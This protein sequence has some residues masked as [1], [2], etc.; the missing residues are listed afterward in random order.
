MRTYNDYYDSR[1]SEIR[2]R[3]V[4]GRLV[5]EGALRIYWGVHG[6]I[7][8]KEDD[9]QRTV[10]T[11][12]KRNSC[13]Y[14]NSDLELPD[15]YDKENF[16]GPEIGMENSPSIESDISITDTMSFEATSIAEDS[17]SI[18]SMCS[19]KEVSPA[20]KSVTL[21]SKLN[22]KELDWDEIDEL[23]QVERKIDDTEK[24]YQTMPSPM[25]SQTS[26]DFSDISPTSESSKT[27]NSVDTVS[28]STNTTTAPAHQTQ[29]DDITTT[30]ITNEGNTSPSIDSS[31]SNTLRA[32]DFDD[33]RKQMSEEYINGTND[34]LTVNDDTLKLNQPIDITRINDS[35]KLYSEN[36]MSKSFNGETAPLMALPKDNQLGK[37]MIILIYHFSRIFLGF[38]SNSAPK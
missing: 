26:S 22:V 6:M 24:L 11:I 33:F 35:L 7:H 30:L 4:N 17:T 27:S 34:M 20:H 25:P 12:R 28:L 16:D 5:F 38:T 32:C 1:S 29:S 18:S 8:L 13:K 2:S 37:N 21:P 23:L 36:I 9:D 14:P 10:V 15:F 19:S 3:E 31:S